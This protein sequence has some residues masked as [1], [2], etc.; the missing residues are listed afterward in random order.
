MVEITFSV[1]TPD[2]FAMR[3]PLRIAGNLSSL[4][5]PFIP[6]SAGTGN[7]ASA[8]PVM[9]KSNNGKYLLSMN[10]PSGA[11][12]RYKY[13]LGDGFWN[14]ELSPTGNFILRELLVPSQ[15]TKLSNKIVTFQSPEM[16][17]VA[18]TFTTPDITPDGDSVF[19]QLNPYD[20]MEP[21]P[22]VSTKANTWEYAIY[23]PTHLVGST[24]YRFCRNGDCK[25]GL[26]SSIENSSFAP[27]IEPNQIT[28]VI[29]GWKNLSSPS[30]QAFVENGGILIEPN[31]GMINGI[32]LSTNYP[33]TWRN[34]IETGLQEIEGTGANWVILTPR[35]S[36]SSAN[37]P[38]IEPTGSQDLTW[39]DL[40]WMINHVKLQELQPIL[41]PQVNYTSVPGFWDSGTK[42]SGWWQSYFDRYQRFILNY[43]DMANLMDVEALII[44]DPTVVQQVQSSPDS[45]VRWSQLIL[46]IRARY[47]GKIIAAVSLPAEQDVP[48][49]ISEVDQVYVLFSPDLS[50]TTNL[51]DTYGA[52]IDLQVFPLVEKFGKPIIIGINNPSNSNS[53]NECIDVNGSCLVYDQTDYPVD[54]M[55][56][57]QILNAA[58]VNSFS[59]SWVAGFISREY[60]PYIKVQDN[61]P[62]IL[63]KEASDVLW[64]W[65]HLIQNIS[66]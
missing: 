30:S 25:N 24:S 63:G 13:T 38:M 51:I 42:D 49:W 64:F 4:G 11:Y 34:T 52:Q 57:A 33:S 39:A 1:E 55:V 44:G 22:M 16:G 61:G 14:A 29:P 65:Y 31:S 41:F 28:G 62:S 45:E 46:D 59:R 54:T 5:N 50:N 20:W 21:I 26:N 7:T 47:T 17:E 27:S 48:G 3:Y 23:S 8:L 19:I 36:I 53:L 35:W 43:A 12:I 66:P 15:D 10:L 60:Y 37:P 9:E 2:E 18:F 6:L 32:E 58:M 56:Q 40:Q